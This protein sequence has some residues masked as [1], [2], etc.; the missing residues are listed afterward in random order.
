MDRRHGG[1]PDA[2]APAYDLH[3]GRDTVCCATRARNNLSGTLWELIHRVDH[4]GNILAFRRSGQNDKA[5]SSLNV[6]YQIDSFSKGT[7]TLEHHVNAHFPPRQ[8]GQTSFPQNGIILAVN[9]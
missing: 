4:G 9:L 8:L 5:R 6:L 1:L 7:R 2:D 3:H